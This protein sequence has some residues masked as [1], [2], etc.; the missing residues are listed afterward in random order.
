MEPCERSSRYLIETI[1]D[2]TRPAALS[3]HFAMDMAT[4]QIEGIQLPPWKAVKSG[5]A[6]QM[7]AIDTTGLDLPT[8]GGIAPKNIITL[9]ENYNAISFMETPFDN[10]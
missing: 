1:P 5:C 2:Q 7:Q 4:S 9:P 10:Q 8:D 3:F 6:L